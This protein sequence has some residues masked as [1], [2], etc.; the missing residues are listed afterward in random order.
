MPVIW[1]AFFYRN[2]YIYRMQTITHAN[3]IHLPG[4]LSIM[5]HNILH[6]TALYDY[7]PKSE[8]DIN[9]WYGEK[10]SANW[11][12]IIA[13]EN[14]V[15]MGYASYGTFRFKEGF[16]HTVEHSVY[17]AEGHTGKGIGQ[18][19]LAELISLAKAQ[20]YHTMI[21][22]IDAQ[23]TS[24]IAFHKKFGFTEAGILK[25]SGYKFGKWLD[26]LFMQLLL[27]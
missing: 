16:K 14:G 7:A 24:S 25:E 4:I 15:V 23:N 27:K 3:S 13:E 1:L 6:S 21:G 10:L 2:K 8:T 11:P 9:Q 12:I 17:V 20:N 26:L 19:L 5:N 22:C 18:L